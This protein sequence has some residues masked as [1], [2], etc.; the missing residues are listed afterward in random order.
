MAHL[1][2]ADDE[3]GMTGLLRDYFE[4]NGYT[5]STAGNGGEALRLSLI[6]I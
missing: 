6:H 1:L 4:L 2:I 3:K 5:V